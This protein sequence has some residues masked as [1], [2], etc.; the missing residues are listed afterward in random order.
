MDVK[1]S[2]V[3][4]QSKSSSSVL[5]SCGIGLNHQRDMIRFSTGINTTVD[6]IDE[7]L[8]HLAKLIPK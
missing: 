2:L 5:T 1:Q 8:V 3:K 7:A 4:I 6:E